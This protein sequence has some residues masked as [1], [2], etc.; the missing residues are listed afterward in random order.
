MFAFMYLHIYQLP[1]EGQNFQERHL[2]IHAKK[3]C[4]TSFFNS[5]NNTPHTDKERSFKIAD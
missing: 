2:H 1:D 4:K 3:A 5:T